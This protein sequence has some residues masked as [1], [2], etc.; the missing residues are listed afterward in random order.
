MLQK[1]VIASLLL[2]ATG[3]AALADSTEGAVVAYDRKAGVIVLEDKTIW[4]LEGSEA[5]PPADLKAG[6]RVKIEYQSEGDDGI[7]MIDAIEPASE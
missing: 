2:L 5:T 7:S 6:D 1:T 4:S 3:S